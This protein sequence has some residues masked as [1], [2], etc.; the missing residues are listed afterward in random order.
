MRRIREWV[1]WRG[2]LG[3]AA[4]IGRL[5]AATAI[6]V[7]LFLA[8]ESLAGYASTL[9]LYPPF[10]AVLL[11]L[12]VR[13]LH[14]SARSAWQPLTLAVPV[15]GPAYL[16]CVLLFVGGTQGDNQYGDDPR[17]RNRDYLRVSIHEPA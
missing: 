9:A 10:F 4:F 14:D 1:E 15:L 5:A 12:T 6:F 16:T 8:L 11:S 3:R 17:A 7:A 2:R 13:R